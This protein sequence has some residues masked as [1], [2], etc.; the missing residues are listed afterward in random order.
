VLKANSPTL[1]TCTIRPSGIF[2]P[3]D[4]TIIPGLYDVIRNKQTAFQVGDNT[5]L[6]DFTYVDNVAHAHLLAAENLL[7]PE[8]GLVKGS[9]AGEA[10]IITNDQPVY[11]WDFARG[12]WAGFGHVNRSRIY[13]PMSLGYWLGLGFILSFLVM[14]TAN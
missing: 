7:T 9:A 2:G 11:F 1:S 4:R 6:W 10:F 14:L 12:V 13:I 8:K 3:G 5:N